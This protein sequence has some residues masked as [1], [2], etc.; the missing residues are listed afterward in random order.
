MESVHFGRTTIANHEYGGVL[1]YFFIIA[2]LIG[3][4]LDQLIGQEDTEI[5]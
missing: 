2:T 5:L 4:P 3:S 1:A